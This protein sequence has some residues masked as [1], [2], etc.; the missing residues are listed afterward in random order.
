[1]TFRSF[2]S[3]TC[4]LAWIQPYAIIEALLSRVQ[5]SLPYR[6]A[7]KIATS[8]PRS[9]EVAILLITPAAVEEVVVGVA[10]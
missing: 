7:A 10:V 6:K 9:S 8:P 1:M 3:P 2:A 5:M 4:W